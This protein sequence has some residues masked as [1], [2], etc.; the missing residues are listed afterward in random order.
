MA[1]S[2]RALEQ[3]DESF[4][5]TA[6]YHALHVPPGEVPLPPSVVQQPDIAR[7]VS[8]WMRQSGDSGV[9]ASAGGVPVGAAWLRVWAGEERGYGFVDRQTPEL[10]MALLPDW[11]GRGI[12]TRLLRRVMEEVDARGQNVSLSV[13]A[14]NGALRLYERAGFVRM[15]Q[16]GDAITMRRPHSG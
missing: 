11:R 14:S 4:L 1:A 10:S 6:L 5:W 16:D 8:K 7:Y 3:A 12:G 2:L 13:S 15:R 9:L